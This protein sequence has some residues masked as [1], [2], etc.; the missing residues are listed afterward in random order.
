MDE[1]EDQSDHY[2]PNP[3]EKPPSPLESCTSEEDNPDGEEDD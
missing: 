2:E 1:P 3:K